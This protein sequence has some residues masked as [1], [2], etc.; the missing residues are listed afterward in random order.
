MMLTAYSP[1]ARGSVMGKKALRKIGEKYGKSEAQVSLRWLIQQ[2]GIVAIPK[3][4]SPDHIRANL[5]I[6]DLELTEREMKT[7]S[8]LSEN[9]RK[10][11]PDFGP[12]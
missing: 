2:E 1:L 4:S 12:W 9:D 11:D 5:E 3:A 10:V 8:E 7:V 6:F